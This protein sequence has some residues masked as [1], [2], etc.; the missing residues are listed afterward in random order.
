MTTP[1]Q[2]TIGELLEAD[3]EIGNALDDTRFDDG[4]GNAGADRQALNRRREIRA[5]L[6]RRHEAC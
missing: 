4:K 6:N 3:R 1:N 5:E 2:M